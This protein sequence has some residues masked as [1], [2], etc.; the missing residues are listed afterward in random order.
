[1]DTRIRNGILT[2]LA[3]AFLPTGVAAQEKDEGVPEG[4][5]SE[6]VA[7]GKKLYAGAGMCGVC[8]GAN[9]EGAVGP[10]LADD[11]WLHSKGTYDEIV[12]QILEGVS[13]GDS[14]SGVPMQPKGGS[15]ISEEQAR[16]VAAYVWSL[17][18]PKAEKP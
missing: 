13:A 9:A 2:A 4:V 16:A 12:T 1:M 18:H 7:A 8:H 17:S 14:K 10:N 3:L 5:T 6:T 11:T 15:S